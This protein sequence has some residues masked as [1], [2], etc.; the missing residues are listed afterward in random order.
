M[1]NIQ[2][3]LLLVQLIALSAGQ[4]LFK[5]AAGAVDV[6][7]KGVLHGLILN[8]GLVAAL[9]IYCGATLL[10]LY[11]FRYTPLHTAYP[12]SALAFLVVPILGS[13]LLSEPLRWTTV[14]L[15]F[16]IIVSVWVRHF[17]PES[18]ALRR[19]PK[20]LSQSRRQSGN[21]FFH[22]KF[23]RPVFCWQQAQDVARR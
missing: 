23:H 12:F 19:C 17:D 21:H 13:M 20:R 9:T 22:Q 15:A 1:T 8:P 3:T 4:I 2:Y 18:L 16:F 11:I 7:S 10:W 14:A 6:K 5:L